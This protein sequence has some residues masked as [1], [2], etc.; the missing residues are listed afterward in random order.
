MLWLVVDRG[1]LAERVVVVGLHRVKTRR[2]EDEHAAAWEAARPGIFGGLLDLAAEV[3]HR[4]P[5]VEVDDLP[6]M[7][8]FAKVLAA[9]D[10]VLGTT[11]LLRYRKRAQQ[12]AADTLDAPFINELVG[13]RLPFADKASAEILAALKPGEPDWKPPR[14]WPK[15]AR[16]V[17]GQLT[18][19]APALRAQGWHIE[20]DDGQNKEG[21]RRWTIRPPEKDPNPDPP[22]PL[23]PPS[24]VSGHKPGGSTG[25]SDRGLFP[26]KPAGGSAGEQ[27][28]QPDSPDPPQNRPVT[29]ENGSTG[30]AGQ[31][32]TPSLVSCRF[33]G[34]GLPTHM[35]S[36]R[37]RG[38][39]HRAPCIRAASSEG[40]S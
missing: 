38:Y 21:T 19:H 15:T 8:D 12:A 13:R 33:C 36:Q 26:A 2:P 14:E 10:E 29:S 6:R 28:G 27:A 32:Y 11:G 18:R 17:T 25:G 34:T 23:N 20:H 37:T 39:C 7:A 35:S 3:H 5:A 16:S 4:L 40:A 9:V 22:D 24:Q 1:D 30:Q 31:E